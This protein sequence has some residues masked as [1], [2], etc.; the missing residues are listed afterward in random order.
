MTG[1]F[2]LIVEDEVDK[3]ITRMRVGRAAHQG[4]V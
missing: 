1:E 2:I 3:L 4:M